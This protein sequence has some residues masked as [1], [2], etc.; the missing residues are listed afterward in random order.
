MDESLETFLELDED[1]E[2]DDTSDGSLALIA[3][4]VFADNLLFLLGLLTLL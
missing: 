3:D 2:V 1:S 4:L